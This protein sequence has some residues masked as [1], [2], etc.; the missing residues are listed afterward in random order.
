MVLPDLPRATWRK[1]RRSNAS[2]C[3]VEVAAAGRA[4]AIRDSKAPTGPVITLTPR[5]WRTFT[6]T[7]KASDLDR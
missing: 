2:G 1:S 7:L 4:V 6:Q 5:E 3:C